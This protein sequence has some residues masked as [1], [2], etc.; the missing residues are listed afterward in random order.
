MKI[1][2]RINS[3]FCF[4]LFLLANNSF[5]QP[6]NLVKEKDGIKLYTRIETNNT[7]KSFK[8]EVVLHAPI[9]KICSR[10]GSAENNDWWDKEI[11]NVKVLGYESDKFIQYYL[12]YNMPW[13]LTNR[14]LVAD[15]R[16]SLDTLS[17]TRTYI[18]G[19][20]RNEIPEN[21]DLVRI[22]KYYQ[23]WTVE[24]LGK[25]NVH[26]ILE[27]FIDPGG[28]VPAWFYNLVVADTPYRAIHSLRGKVLLDK[29]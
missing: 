20:L 5:C 16:I 27:G 23:K 12:V 6:W 18:A 9:D 8:G 15:I 13:P 26:M 17:G 2:F 1:K 11:S 10:L 22:H 7:L 25:G 28:N 24:P 21:P 4:L 14:D 19:P 3:C 29:P